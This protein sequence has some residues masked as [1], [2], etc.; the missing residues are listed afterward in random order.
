MGAC[1]SSKSIEYQN[2]SANVVLLN[3]ELR[4]FPV[5]ITVFQVL[6]Q[7]ENSSADSFICNSDCLYFDDYIPALAPED[8][9]QESQIYFVLPRTKLHY[10]LSASDMAALAVKASVALDKINA[11]SAS[12]HRRKRKA[13][14]SPVM[15]LDQNIEKKS[16]VNNNNTMKPSTSARLGV[17]RSSSV[18]K[19][20][21]YSSRRAKMAARSFRIR[22]ST[23]YEGSVAYAPF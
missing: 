18:R 13:R 6:L 22:L 14:I 10:R 9:L 15:V 17:S 12:S 21:R 7:L 23:I 11:A 16:S 5:P 19:L 1:L 8:A 3:G 4:Q 2:P 20:Q